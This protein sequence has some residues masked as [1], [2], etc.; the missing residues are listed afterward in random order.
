MGRGD[1]RYGDVVNGSSRA[2]IGSAIVHTVGD[3]QTA[4]AQLAVGFDQLYIEL[5]TKA[6]GAT[7]EHPQGLASQAKPADVEWWK[8]VA[9]PVF[10]AWTNFKAARSAENWTHGGSYIAYGEQF[11]TSWDEYQKWFQQLADLRAASAKRFGTLSSPA[12]APLATTAVEDVGGFFSGLGRDV[13]DK[14]G[15]GW[16]LAK[17]AVY[18]GLAIGALIVVGSAVTNMRNRQDPMA[19]YLAA[20]RRGGKAAALAA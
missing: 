12:P 17:V 18:G 14:L 13:K 6:L 3:R 8:S 4:L 9:V 7:P 11:S 1:Y 20:A 15:E 16:T 10:T 19:P 5:Q 2:R